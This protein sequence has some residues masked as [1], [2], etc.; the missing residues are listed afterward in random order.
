MESFFIM[1]L[2]KFKVVQL[3]DIIFQPHFNTEI[4]ELIGNDIRFKRDVVVNFQ[5]ISMDENIEGEKSSRRRL[6]WTIYFEVDGYIY[7]PQNDIE[8][9]IR[10]VYLDFFANSKTLGATGDHF[11]SIDTEVVPYD[12]SAEDWRKDP[13]FKQEWSADKP[14]PRRET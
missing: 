7:P 10:T 2:L 9:E 8:G 4:T 5:S 1:D 13:K 3:G 14:H 6:Q 11:E 12:V